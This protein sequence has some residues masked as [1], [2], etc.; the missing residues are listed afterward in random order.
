VRSV[1]KVLHFTLISDLVR[2]PCTRTLQPS[3]SDIREARTEP[4]VAAAPV[5]SKD[6]A[7]RLIPG[8]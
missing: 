7:L 2:W 1:L 3:W 6:Q 5:L 8:R 4:P